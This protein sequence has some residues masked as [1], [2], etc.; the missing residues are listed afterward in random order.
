MT[1]SA[2]RSARGA[3]QQFLT[4]VEVARA[5]GVDAHVVRF[6]ARTGLIRPARHAANGYRQFLPLDVKRV[7]FVRAAQSL[8]FTLAEIK[9]IMRQ[10][11][12]RNTPCPLVREIITQRLAE[13]RERLR[14]VQA[15]QERMQEANE[16]W[17]RMPDQFP[18]GDV[19]CA[20]IEAVA[21]EATI[22]P[23]PRTARALRRETS[24]K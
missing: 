16:A 23:S 2:R 5:A 8:G 13:N 3:A 19:V 1:A 6:Y 20:L 24:R 15:L 17:S 18:T 10:S 4:V 7:R 21:D 22:P 9:E 11:H 12:L 14:Y